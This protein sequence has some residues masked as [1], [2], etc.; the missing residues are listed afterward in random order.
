LVVQAIPECVTYRNRM[1]ALR[2][3]FSWMS[4]KKILISSLL[5]FPSSA[6]NSSRQ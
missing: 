6:L 2:S 5:F 3:D 1:T 4:D